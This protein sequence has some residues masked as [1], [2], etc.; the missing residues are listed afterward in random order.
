MTCDVLAEEV[1]YL[2]DVVSRA[3]ADRAW[4]RQ[5]EGERAGGEP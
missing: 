2:E 3:N 1:R 5:R 4:I